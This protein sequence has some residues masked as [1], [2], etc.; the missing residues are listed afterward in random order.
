MQRIQQSS[1]YIIHNIVLLVNTKLGK[2][3]IKM[4]HDRSVLNF[5]RI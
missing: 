1:L 3:V 5:K 2:L 4:T